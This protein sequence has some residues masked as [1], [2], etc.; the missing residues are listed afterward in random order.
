MANKTK[1]IIIDSIFGGHSA[2]ENFAAEDEFAYSAAIDPDQSIASIVP[3]SNL[4]P[5]GYIFPTYSNILT[6]SFQ[7]FINWLKP[8][9]KTRD[10][11]VYGLNGTI[12]TTQGVAGDI[13]YITSLVNSVGGGSEY[14]DNYM[15]FATQSTVARFGPLNGAPVMNTDFWGSSL[16]KAALTAL[17]ASSSI[18]SPNRPL[19]RHSD[20]KLYFPDVVGGQGVAH[21][22]STKKTTVEGDTDNGSVFNAVD[23]PPGFIV[24]D[25]ESYGTDMAFALYE[26]TEEVPGPT[27]KAK[28]AFWDTSNPT[29]YDKLIYSEFP[30]PFIFALKN[31]NGVLYTVSGELGATPGRYGIRIC[32]FIG[33]YSFE[34][35]AFIANVTP[36]SPAG[37]DAF[38]NKF[39]FGVLATGFSGAR[40]V[41]AVTGYNTGPTNPFPAIFTVGSRISPISNKVFCP[42]A[43]PSL[44]G[45][46]GK[47]AVCLVGQSTFNP[48]YLVGVDRF[49]ATL[50]SDTI[51]YLQSLF[52][53]KKYRIG[54]PFK[55]TKLT[56]NLVNAFESTNS[57]FVRPAFYIDSGNKS[58]AT[59]LNSVSYSSHQTKRHIVLK[60]I[61][62]TGNYDFNL[63]LIQ[64][65]YLASAQPVATEAAPP[66]IALPI[67]I[68]YEPIDD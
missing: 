21:V 50:G 35:V 36:P 67:I 10:V 46:S 2:Y 22:I 58:A 27:S 28:I 15:Y 68:E 66:V 51:G 11:Y 19:H 54:S 55:I 40:T 38:L 23:F 9:P 24:S 42:A 39:V 41:S 32:R 49:L 4:N 16:G 34:Q 65:S 1:Q 61:N 43:I 20:G 17:P 7:D 45:V 64:D 57:T 44:F 48:Q 26:G 25:L 33:G 5:S 62:L 52:I 31:A 18:I 63:E 37:V 13:T 53:S 14:C 3:Y 47:M 12:A 6:S 59:T 30:D 8:N 29:T 60:P 56:F